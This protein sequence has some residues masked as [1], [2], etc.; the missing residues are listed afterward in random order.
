[1]CSNFNGLSN[2]ATEMA[3]TWLLFV[4][5]HYPN[6]PHDLNTKL[7]CYSDPQCID[8]NLLNYF[9]GTRQKCNEPLPSCQNFRIKMGP[10]RRKKKFSRTWSTKWTLWDN[11]WVFNWRLVPL[12]N[13][14]CTVGIWNSDLPGFWMVKKRLGCK[15]SRLELNL[16]SRSPAIWNPDKWL[17]LQK[18]CEIL[19]LWPTSGFWMVQFQIVRTI[20]IAIAKAQPFE[21][22]PLKSP[23]F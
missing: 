16:K 9:Y 21:I 2:H 3:Q 17:P 14:L 20:A 11:R 15:W 19:V 6:N 22:R 7:V 12:N 23:D 10:L 5:N 8:W 13:G 1:M 4:Q 18:P